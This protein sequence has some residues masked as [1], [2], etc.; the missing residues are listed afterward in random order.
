LAQKEKDTSDN[1]NCKRA[2]DALQKETSILQEVMNG[3]ENMHLVYLDRDFN[4]VRVNEAYAKTCGYKPEEMI[5]KNHFT[6]YPHEENEAIFKGVRDTGL[7][8]VFHDKPF[9]FPDQSERGVTYWDWTLKPVKNGAGE[10]NGLVFSLVETTERKKVEEELKKSEERYR[11]YIEVTGELGWTTNAEGEVVED[12]PSWRN[13]TGQSFEEIKGSGWSNALHPDDLKNTLKVWRQSIR[14]KRKYEVE[15]RIRRHDGVYR[16]FLARGEPVFNQD[17]TVREW[18]GICIDI[19]K[20]KKVEE[21]LKKSGWVARQRAEEL[22]EL[23]QKLEEK[24]TEV[25]EYATRMEELAQERAM[26]LQEAE[27]LAAIGAT[28]GMVGHDIRNPLQSIMGDLYLIASDIAS[29]PKS[30]EKDSIK[31]SISAI[32]KSAEYIDKIIQDLQDYAKP[33]KPIVQETDFEDLCE[34]VLFKNGCEENIDASLNVESDARILVADPMLLRRILTN[35][36]NN[37]VQAMPDGGKLDVCA[38]REGDEVA[39]TVQDSGVGIPEDAKDKMF[40]PLFTTKAKGQGL[41]LA[42][43]KRL[44]ETLGGTVTFESEEGKDTKFTI[45]L[46][47]KK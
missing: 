6:L 8:A 12:M 43:V 20:R 39:I 40:T 47:Q 34:D 36:V 19:T 11:S 5:G 26:K 46:P 14:E 23:Q 2:Q 33:P 22:E 42:V 32:R 29:M 24:T 31:E 41:G 9:V 15:Y 7:P 21:A 3:A 16:Y 45:R 37:A 38:F 10:V 44:T 4:F 25:E 13:F 35:L 18:V 1:Q 30:E 27:R 28:A 17:G